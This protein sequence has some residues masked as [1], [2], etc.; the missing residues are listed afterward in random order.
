MAKSEVHGDESL[1]YSQLVWYRDAL[2]PTNPGSSCVVEC[3]P[4]TSC[5]QRLFVCYGA[6]IEGFQWCRPLLFIDETFLRSKHKGQ[7]IG[8]TGKNG[9]QGIVIKLVNSCIL[10]LYYD[11]S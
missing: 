4:R 5:F 9:N 6:C 8:A 11:G 3:D 1:S 7:L 10:I 2:V